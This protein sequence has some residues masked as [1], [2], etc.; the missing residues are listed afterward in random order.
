MSTRRAYINNTVACLFR[1]QPRMGSWLECTPGARL[2]WWWCWWGTCPP[3]NTLSWIQRWASSPSWGL[4]CPSGKTIVIL[5]VDL[6]GSVWIDHVKRLSLPTLWW[7][8][9]INHI[10]LIWED[11]AKS[12]GCDSGCLFK[13]NS[14]SDSSRSTFWSC[15]NSVE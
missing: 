10:E 15:L 9:P 4:T 5:C 8:M 7:V 2:G 1:L 3:P 11:G 12:F 13:F 14:N 6:E